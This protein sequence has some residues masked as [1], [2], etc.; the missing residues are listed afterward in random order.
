MSWMAFVEGFART[1]SDIIAERRDEAK[2][3]KERMREMA[4]RNRSKIQAMNE[5]VKQ[6][7]A[8]VTRA[9]NLGASD[10]Q[11]SMALDTSPTALRDMVTTLTNLKNNP[12]TAGAFGPEMIARAYIVPEDYTNVNTDAAA[13]F[14]SDF[15]VG[16]V[17]G[18]EDSGVLGRLFNAG[19]MGTARAQLDQE[20]LAG[21]NMS[22]FD[23]AGLGDFDFYNTLSP[24]TVGSFVQPQVMDAERSNTEMMRYLQKY[25]A[26]MDTTEAQIA[27]A[28]DVWKIQEINRRDAAGEPPLEL[29]DERAYMA[30]LQDQARQVRERSIAQHFATAGQD[31]IGFN[32]AMAPLVA[33]SGIDPLTK[34]AA[35]LLDPTFVIEP[36]IGETGLDSSPETG[37]LGPQQERLPIQTAEDEYDAQSVIPIYERGVEGVAYYVEPATGRMFVPGSR[38]FISNVDVRRIA[39]GDPNLLSLTPDMSQPFSGEQITDEM[40]LA[41]SEVTSTPEAAPQSEGLMAPEEEQPAPVIIDMTPVQNLE[42]VTNAQDYLRKLAEEK[43]QMDADPSYIG[44]IGDDGSGSVELARERLE[45]AAIMARQAMLEGIAGAIPSQAE[46][47]TAV[48]NER[49]REGASASAFDMDAIQD[50]IRAEW[51]DKYKGLY[52]RGGDAI[53]VEARPVDADEAAQW[54]RLYG[55]SHNANG[56][57]LPQRRGS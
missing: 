32:Q 6:N 16:D 21:T 17:E 20:M 54:D 31:I 10:A 35:Q 3:Y 2:D 52:T 23:A 40:I 51:D 22:I 56:T 24:G 50:E 7:Q 49:V 53:I 36:G 45:E 48:Y 28:F 30:V 33:A 44:P 1:T 46:Y 55:D 27:S 38:N 25:K 41:R 39:Q 13:R 15:Q 19:A 29:E 9:R 11:I 12:A 34:Y 5:S 8:F 57:P 42:Q 43:A 18:P 47:V 37:G 26:I 14:G 4:E